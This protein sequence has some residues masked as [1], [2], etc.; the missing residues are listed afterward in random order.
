MKTFA[1]IGLPRSGTTLC[2]QI[3]SRIF[4]D[5]TMSHELEGFNVD[6]IIIRDIR[7]CI[8]S[9]KQ[10]EKFDFGKIKTSDDINM[11]LEDNFILKSAKNIF[12]QVKDEIPILKYEIFH[13]DRS[14]IYELV[15]NRFNIKVS[16]E[17]E[18]AINKET[19]LD[20]NKKIQ[21]NFSKFEE[22]DKESG[23]HGNH[24]NG[25]EV[26]KWQRLIPIELHFYFKRR[27]IEMIG[28]DAY[29]FFT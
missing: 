13:E 14:S 3:F 16:K 2:K 18:D 19:S 10:T 12:P 11:L 4:T 28:V 27:L 17:T 29:I 23:I 15:R 20:E 25:G 24:I 5:V 26:G 8:V 7:D 9:L 22:W 6:L 1:A 21:Q